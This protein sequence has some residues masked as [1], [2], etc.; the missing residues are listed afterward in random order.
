[1]H[2]RPILHTALKQK[3]IC[4]IKNITLSRNSTSLC[5]C[6]LEAMVRGVASCMAGHV[7]SRLALFCSNRVT[8]L[9]LPLAQA[10]D[11]GK[12]PEGPIRFTFAP[13]IENTCACCTFG[14]KENQWQ[15]LKLTRTHC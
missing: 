7:F 2:T 8:I 1:M 10:S 9:M 6:M 3:I 5:C 11:M 15:I 4:N 14:L 13:G 12:R